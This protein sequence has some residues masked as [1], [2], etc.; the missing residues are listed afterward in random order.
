MQD[1]VINFVN[2]VTGKPKGDTRIH[3]MFERYCDFSIKSG[4][5]WSRKAQVSREH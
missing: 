1:I 4:T 3:V 2:Y 5:R